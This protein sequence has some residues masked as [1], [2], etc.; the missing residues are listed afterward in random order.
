MRLECAYFQGNPTKTQP[1]A[2]VLVETVENGK[3]RAAPYVPQS[4]VIKLASEDGDYGCNLASCAP[5]WVLGNNRCNLVSCELY[6]GS[7]DHGCNLTSCMPCWV[8]WDNG[9]NL[10]SRAPY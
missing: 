1:M 10:G 2:A 3:K 9:R 6:L 5:Y 7:G 4:A 8:Q